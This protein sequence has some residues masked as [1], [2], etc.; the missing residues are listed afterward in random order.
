MENQIEKNMEDQTDTGLMLG[1]I[2]V[3][4]NLMVLGFSY[5][6]WSGVARINIKMILVIIQACMVF[7]LQR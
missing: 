6:R 2:G 7:F 1:N 3:V 4:T 5:A